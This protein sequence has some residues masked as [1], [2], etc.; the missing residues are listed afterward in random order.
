MRP[1]PSVCLLLFACGAPGVDGTTSTSETEGGG[2]GKADRS[3]VAEAAAER[4]IVSTDLVLDL[5]ARRGRATLTL[6]RSSAPARLEVGDL[7]LESVSTPDGDPI[8]YREIT[9]GR[10]E[11]DLPGARTAVVFDYA[12]AQ[13]GRLNGW[14]ATPGFSFLWPAFCA[15]LFPCHTNP[16]DGTTFTLAV[17]GVPAGKTAI[18]PEKIETPAPAYQLGITLGAYEYEKLGETEAGTEVGIYFEAPGRD[19]A[20]SGAANLAGY[21]GWLE[22][23]V[24]PY[25]FGPRVASVS[26]DWGPGD[27]G[28]LEHH[29]YWH[30]DD[31]QMHD[32]NTHAHEAAHGWFGNGVRIA[33]WE[34]LVLSEGVVTYLAARAIEAVEGASAGLAQWEAYRT[35]LDDL[36]AGGEDTP[37]WVPETCNAIDL[38]AHPLWSLVTYYRGAFFLRAVEN[39]VG[40]E[41]FDAALAAFYRKH[42]GQDDARTQDLLD[43][44]ARDTGFDPTPLAERW[45]LQTGLPAE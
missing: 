31:G 40:R 18:F 3:A 20:L 12:F 34:D 8:A 2:D 10:I 37:A 39:Q 28:G 41:R 24:G 43:A 22:K 23:S 5:T 25:L 16:A 26:V 44:L 17:A 15:N 6:A 36:V 27:F 4:D 13:H 21:F 42:G 38:T 19:A 30:I 29:P 7:R 35:E 11:L 32:P 33:C 9:E 45:L 14:D 1:L